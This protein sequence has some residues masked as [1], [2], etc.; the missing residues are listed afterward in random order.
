MKVKLFFI[1]ITLI[2]FLFMSCVMTSDGQIYFP[3]IIFQ[4]N[5]YD[6]VAAEG[7]WIEN[8]GPDKIEIFVR[9]GT[10]ILGKYELYESH[11][12]TSSYRYNGYVWRCN[13]GGYW[14]WEYIK[15]TSR[16]LWWRYTVRSEKRYSTGILKYRILT[17]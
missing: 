10:D 6:W 2:G 11:I 5:N 17:H 1:V 4:S 13:P 7:L 8:K 16:K 3:V 12:W 9:S 15:Y 14:R